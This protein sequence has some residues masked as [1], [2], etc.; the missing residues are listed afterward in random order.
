MKP[1]FTTM[2]KSGEVYHKMRDQSVDQVAERPRNI[3]NPSDE[4][5][6]ILTYI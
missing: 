4:G 3:F 5:C 6:G 2:V 1:S